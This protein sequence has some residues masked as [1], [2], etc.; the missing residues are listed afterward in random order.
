MKKWLGMYVVLVL[1]AFHGYS[2]ADDEEMEEKSSITMEEVVVTATR[3]EQDVEKVP[4]N[5]ASLLHH[6][7]IKLIADKG[8]NVLAS[9]HDGKAEGHPYLSQVVHSLHYLLEDPHTPASICFLLE[10][11]QTEDNEHIAQ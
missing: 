10:A 8:I 11:L 6:H 5:E 1:L 2:L 3:A 9:D 7:I 4:A